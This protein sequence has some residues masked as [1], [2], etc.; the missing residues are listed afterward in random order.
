MRIAFVTTEYN[1]NGQVYGGLA[2][3]LEKIAEVL[4]ARGQEVT[5]LTLAS[6][7]Y[8]LEVKGIRIHAVKEKNHILFLL[9]DVF[10][11]FTLHKAMLWLA[12]SWTMNQKLKKL[13]L[14]QP[15]DIVQ[16]ASTQALAFFA[17]SNIPWCIRNSGL[18]YQYNRAIGINNYW[19]R[20]KEKLQVITLKSARF[21]YGPS[22]TTNELFLRDHG[23][24]STLIRTPLPLAF[25]E[26]EAAKSN[27][28]EHPLDGHRF[29]LFFGT[30]NELK[31]VQY[32]G[33]VLPKLFE[34][35]PEI[36]FVFCGRDGQ[37]G[38]VSAND[39]LIQYAGKHASNL[40]FT[41]VLSQE[42]L[43][44]WIIAANVIT[45]PSVVD[46]APNTLIEALSYNKVVVCSNEGSM[47]EMIKNG[48]NGFL[49][50][51]SNPAQYSETIQNV[52]ELSDIQK[53]DIQFSIQ[54]TILNHNPESI[55][56]QTLKFYKKVINDWKH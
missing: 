36:R 53:K 49:C 1:H 52:L 19:E 9:L 5:I 33:P 42:E 50:D 48:K 21:L 25:K 14:E 41:G 55:A 3:Y 2:S 23:K 31:G 38:Q 29:I 8:D 40:V 35:D 32:I 17:P 28:N 45:L 26:A 18:L 20:Q 34:Y 47:M 43:S 24:H 30:L 37:V 11:L 46:N 27:Q 6:E 10:T 13:H 12:K 56:D 16:Y 22:S 39:Y 4:H 51:V 44:Q 7:N 15:L 54:E